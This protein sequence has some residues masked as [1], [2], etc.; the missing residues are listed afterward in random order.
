MSVMAMYVIFNTQKFVSSEFLSGFN[1][2]CLFQSFQSIIQYFN[3]AK[4]LKLK[5]GLH[6]AAM[7][8]E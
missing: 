8:Y 6:K 1:D 7:L 4:K 2:P 3:I 5:C